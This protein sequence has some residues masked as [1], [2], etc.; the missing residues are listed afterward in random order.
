MLQP[1]LCEMQRSITTAVDSTTCSRFSLQHTLGVTSH[2]KEKHV[3]SHYLSVFH[4]HGENT[5]YIN[6]GKGKT[7]AQRGVSLTRG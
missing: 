7:M 6:L 5:P 2:L 1:Q 3:G 4:P